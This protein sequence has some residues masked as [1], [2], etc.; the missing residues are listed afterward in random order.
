MIKCLLFLSELDE[1]LPGT[2]RQVVSE[3]QTN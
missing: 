2:P 1:L 3:T